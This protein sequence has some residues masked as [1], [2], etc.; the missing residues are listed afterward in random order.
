ME[1]RSHPTVDEIYN[2]LVKQLP[3]L[4]K[5]TVYNTLSLFMELNLARM[6]TIEDNEARFDI[7]VSNHGHF[8][9]EACRR[10]YDFP[11][12]MDSVVT[13]G[14]D[15]FEIKEKDFYFKG[16]CPDCLQTKNEK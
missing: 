7:D 3:T 5:T 15:G 11:V 13:D 16:I 2:D 14:L 12:S 8:K 9:C 4:S 6:I 1:K 10:I